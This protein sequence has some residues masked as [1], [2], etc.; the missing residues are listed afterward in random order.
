MNAWEKTV[1]S[2]TYFKLTRCAN[3]ESVNEMPDFKART[4]SIKGGA[5]I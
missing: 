3:R 5:S 4:L 1:A 2:K